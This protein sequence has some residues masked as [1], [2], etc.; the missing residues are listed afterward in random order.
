MLTSNQSK[1]ILD[2]YINQLV[3]NTTIAYNADRSASAT[4]AWTDIN[5][6]IRTAIIQKF[7]ANKT[8]I[9]NSTIWSKLVINDYTGISE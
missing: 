8:M 4:Q 1:E 7:K 3:A 5:I 6:N 2:G 9:R